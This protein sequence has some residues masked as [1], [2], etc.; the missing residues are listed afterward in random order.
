MA[1]AKI[2]PPLSQV[3]RLRER[4][5][6]QAEEIRQLREL[7]SPHKLFPLRWE[8][9]PNEEALLSMLLARSP[10]V[11]TSEEISS[12]LFRRGNPRDSYTTEKYAQVY[13]HKLRK[14]LARE[15]IL[16]HTRWGVGYYIDKPTA[17]AINE[18]CVRESRGED[19]RDAKSVI[20]IQADYKIADGGEFEHHGVVGC[21]AQLAKL[22]AELHAEGVKRWPQMVRENFDDYLRSVL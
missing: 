20:I 16:I 22:I 19:T 1:L 10:L 15:G 18:L 2:N 17:D 13:V 6:E 12:T 4:I 14:K 9:T 21:P 3:E 5:D 11:R 8:L 7:V